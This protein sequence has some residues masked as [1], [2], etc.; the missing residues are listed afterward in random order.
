MT[1]SSK[2][3]S[4][5][6][7][8]FAEEKDNHT[9]AGS[10]EKWKLLIVDDEEDVHKVTKLVLGGFS[11]SGREIELISSYSRSDA[12]KKLREIP[13]IAI[14]LLDVVME[15]DD[16]GLRLVKFIRNDL[17]NNLARIILRTGQPGQAPEAKIV[18]QYDINDYKSKTE[19]TAEKLITTVVSALR[20]YRDIVTIDRSRKGLEK[21]INASATIFELQSLKTFVSGVLLQLV[22]ILHLDRDAFYCHA[23][24]LTASTMDGELKIIAATG[25]Y[26]SS[27]INKRV[28]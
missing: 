24:G 5:D 15:E 12:E 3:S 11:F 13:D 17:G 10:R 26:N 16:A 25:R 1:D 9:S 8:V 21:I 18:I 23:S 20:S 27:I 4:A 6:A 7:L 14:I 22:S 28:S 19:L 2:H